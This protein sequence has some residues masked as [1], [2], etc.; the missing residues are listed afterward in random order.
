VL[1][2]TYLE[3]GNDK[4]AITE[5]EQAAKIEPE[6]PQIHFNLAKA[7]AEANV[8]DKAEEQREIFTRLNALAEQQ[9]SQQGSQSY[10]AH[11]AADST[12]SPA[13]P[14]KANKPD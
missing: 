6:S 8:A 2:R 7:Y 5:L 10:G 3:L 9:R 12:F 13:E 4:L 14:T 1:G 11:N